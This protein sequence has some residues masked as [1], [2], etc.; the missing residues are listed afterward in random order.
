MHFSKVTQVFFE[1]VCL[2]VQG[3]QRKTKRF[4]LFARNTSSHSMRNHFVSFALATIP[5]SIVRIV[6]TLATK[7]RAP[8]TQRKKQLSGSP[9]PNLSVRRIFRGPGRW[10]HNLTA[11][12][13]WKCSG[14]ANGNSEHRRR[15]LTRGLNKYKTC[16]IDRFGFTSNRNGFLFSTD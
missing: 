1:L 11:E 6:Q 14:M 15:K 3:T 2:P 10:A 13:R 4:S 16:F 5:I 7:K 8:A 12:S 9:R